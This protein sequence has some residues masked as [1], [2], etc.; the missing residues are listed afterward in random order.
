M[1]KINFNS[2]KSRM[3]IGYGSMAMLIVIVVFIT[4]SQIANIMKMGNDVLE[5]KQPS[6]M[7]VDA[8]KSGVRHSNI[9]VQNYLLSGNEQLK[10]EITD[11]WN[12]EIQSAKD[13]I[14]SL[15]THWNN[16]ENIIIYEKLSRLAERIKKNQQEV[17]NN[18]QF[19]GGDVSLSLFNYPNMEGDTI[20]GTNDLQNWIDDELNNQSSN[21]NPNGLLYEEN[22][23]ALSDEFD[24]RAGVLCSNLEKQSLEIG[25]QIFAARDRFVIVETTIVIVAIILCFILYRFA[26]K[27]IKSSIDT[28]QDEVK[29]LSEGNI[30]ETKAHTNDE[31]DIILEEIHTLSSN[32]ANVKDFALEVGKGSFDSDISVFNNQGDIGTSLAEMRDSLKN[33]SEEARIRNW[34][35]KGSAEFGDILRK[36]NNNIAELSNHVIT[37][38][39]KYLNANQGSIFIVDEDENG[40]ESL[41]LT[42][43]YAYDRKKFIEKTIQPGQGLVGQVYLEK[44]SI[45]MKELPKNYITITSGLGKATPNSIFIV[46]LIANNIVYGVIEIGTFT[47]FTENERKFIE[48]VGE[49][50]A[51]SVQSV[52]INE[53]TNRLLED[54]QQMTEEMRAQ[55]EEMRQNMEELQ[56]T[57]EEMER[58]QKENNERLTAMEKSGLAYVE[59]TPSGEIITA[60][61]TFIKLFGYNSIDEIKGRHHRIFVSNEY[62]N[63]EEY[64]SFWDNLRTG[65]IQSGIFDRYTKN[66]RKI[67]VKG[68]YTVLRNQNDEITKIIK[69]A[70]DISEIY[71]NL[72]ALQ[73]EKVTLNDQLENIEGKIQGTGEGGLDDLKKYQ[74][75]LKK[76]LINKLQKNEDE[77]KASLE[78]QKRNLGLS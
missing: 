4:L 19:G 51:S 57:Q 20:Y 10:K 66:G 9:T 22:L 58:S 32:L 43:T 74:K 44:Q 45:Y 54:S 35:N 5:N 8:M 39:V 16:P 53:R 60:D 24:E 64:H 72:A 1:K 7:Y 77:L 6:R 42:A 78:K 21:S 65:E 3:I 12:K 37:F 41:H 46:P 2:I 25:E 29:I 13:S 31:L 26:R 40:E 38:M 15:K 69:F 71:Q 56:A 75:Q 73:K 18:A 47:E 61:E 59:F 48:D 14:D 17:L 76:S 68:T 33:V 49:N 28:L 67:H 62:A 11:I 30:P 50:I 36:F 23:K 63:S 70:F 34:T 55:E 27:Q 52:K